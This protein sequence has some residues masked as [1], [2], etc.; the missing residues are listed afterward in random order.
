MVRF[1]PR[2]PNYS[3]SKAN[4]A[5]MLG[6]DLVL[7]HNSSI[8]VSVVALD[9]VCCGSQTINYTFQ[10]GSAIN[11]STTICHFMLSGFVTELI[12]LIA[13]RKENLSG[14]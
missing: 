13:S 1:F 5:F 8:F 12:V 9:P 10:T 7:D 4:L 14:V 2:V 11:L 6:S 3:K